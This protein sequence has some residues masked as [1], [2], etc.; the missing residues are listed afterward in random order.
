MTVFV[1]Y[2]NKQPCQS[3]EFITYV[4]VIVLLVVF[5]YTE[6]TMIYNHLHEANIYLVYLTSKYTLLNTTDYPVSPP[7]N[8]KSTE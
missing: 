6:C 5:V 3:Y 4:F 1:D 7:R 8:S 2:Y